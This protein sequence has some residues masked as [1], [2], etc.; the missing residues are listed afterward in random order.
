MLF[1]ASCNHSRTSSKLEGKEDSVQNDSGTYNLQSQDTIAEAVN[2]SD[3][4][5]WND[6]P[7]TD[8]VQP[9]DFEKWLKIMNHIK[10]NY[11]AR[12]TTNMLEGIG[13][14]A[15]YEKDDIDEDS[16]KDV[17]LMYG[18]QTK[19]MTD[20]TGK[21]YHTFDGSHAIL[22]QVFA[23]TS[24]GAEIGFHNPADLKDFMEQAVKRGVI[25]SPN[26]RL[27]VCD[28]PIG[29]GVHK[30]KKVYEHTEMGKGMYKELY[31]LRPVYEPEAEW[32]ICYI[33]LDFLRHRIDV[34]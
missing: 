5:S 33:T 22:F 29:E 15:L 3:A 31:Y 30:L 10:D 24:S 4:L 27:I 2:E 18:R 14:K 25:E 34:E 8:D 13:L 9:L 6:I 12:P 28:K 16:I 1:C 26:G 32:Q 17:H 21:R 19:C 11:W 23:Y 20:S 7:T